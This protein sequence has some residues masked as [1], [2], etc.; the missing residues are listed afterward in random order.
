MFPAS[1]A[2]SPAD[3]L[4]ASLGEEFFSEAV[5]IA[6]DLRQTGIRVSLYPEAV[7]KPQKPLSYAD[8]QKIPLAILIGEDEHKNGVVT[9]RNLIARSQEKP[10]RDNTVDVVRGML[11]ANTQN[12]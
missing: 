1:L 6:T 10:S 3:V 11:S 4:V 7:N 2:T 5:A 9:V 12:R 8:A